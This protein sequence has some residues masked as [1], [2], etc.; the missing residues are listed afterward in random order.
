MIGKNKI[1]KLPYEVTK[2]FKFN[3]KPFNIGDVFE[4]Q[5][6]CYNCRNLLKGGFIK[7]FDLDKYA[8]TARHN[9]FKFKGNTY[10]RDE[11]IPSLDF[12]GFE[13][14]FE[15]GFVDLNLIDKNIQEVIIE[16]EQETEE[17]KIKYSALAKEYDMKFK[18][19]KLAL[20]S[21]FE[22]EISSH[23]SN[24]DEKLLPEFRKFLDEQTKI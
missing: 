21:K 17:I 20:C 8:I 13:K 11:Q 19:L 15:N 18:D 2:P 3:T 22:I 4:F 24:V 23:M 16:E 9:N 14:L 5:P 7:P 1:L 10:S 12:K 6:Q